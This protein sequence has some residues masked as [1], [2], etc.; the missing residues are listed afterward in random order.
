MP[1]A[2]T[3]TLRDADRLAENLLRDANEHGLDII[4]RDSFNEAYIR[5]LSGT[6]ALDNQEL[7]ENTFK[8]I[9]KIKSDVKDEKLFK[10]AGGKNLTQDQ[11]Q[12]SKTIVKSRRE[13]IKHGSQKVDLQGFDTKREKVINRF[14]VSGKQGKQFVFAR[15][16]TVRTRGKK[17]T[18]RLR[19]RFGRFVKR[20]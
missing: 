15:E 11:R 14:N 9:K 7:R 8:F 18:I 1:T 10:K 17:T 20:L 16:D 6:D 19:D 5:Y 13:F 12:T 2:R 3:T 4:D